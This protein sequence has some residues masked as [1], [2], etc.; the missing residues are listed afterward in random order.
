MDWAKDFV[1]VFSSY[2]SSGMQLPKLHSWCYHMVSAIQKYGSINSMTTETYET[3]HKYYVKNPYRMSNKKNYMKQILK[4]VSFNYYFFYYNCY[5][6]IIFQI[7][8]QKLT[9][10]EAPKK[11]RKAN[12][13][14]KLLWTLKLNDIDHFLS[15]N[16]DMNML[17]IEGFQ[18]ML[19]GLDEFFE[20][21]SNITIH[22]N[23]RVE[24]FSSAS[25]ES[26]DIICAIF[27]FHG[28]SI[29]SN[30]VIC[31]KEDNNDVNWYSM[32]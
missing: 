5:K 27:N 17:H 3:L 4:T 11:Y 19:I 7:N 1:K 6:S 9:E 16:K 28:K 12:S 13:F 20:E 15:H 2:N 8:R 18:N 24:V 22:D 21:E 14:G 32:V 26:T 10:H 29:F 31:A 23:H 30:V 25:L